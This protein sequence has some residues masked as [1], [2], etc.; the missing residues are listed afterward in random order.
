MAF[1]YPECATCAHHF[2][3]AFICEDCDDGDQFEP[4]EQARAF[5]TLVT[6]ALKQ[7]PQAISTI[8]VVS[9]HMLPTPTLKKPESK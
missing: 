8:R 1:L 7:L 4:D 9:Q 2:K 6:Q 5:K 3:H